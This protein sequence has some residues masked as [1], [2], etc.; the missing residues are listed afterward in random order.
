MESRPRTTTE[1]LEIPR[2]M[3]MAEAARIEKFAPSDLARLRCELMKSK[4][5]SWQAAELLANFLSGRGY[6]V[7]SCAM[8]TA[9]PSMDI[10]GGSHEAMQIALEKVAYVM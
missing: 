5:D 3:R 2:E 7:N 10:L 8:R 1:I 4:M 6:G 9:V